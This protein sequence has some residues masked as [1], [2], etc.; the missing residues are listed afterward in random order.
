MADRVGLAKSRA[1]V[2][3][4]LFGRDGEPPLTVGR[5]RIEH[6]LGAGGMGI[7][8][9]AHDEELDR[10]IAV[11]LIA[12]GT[13]DDNERTTSRLRRE[14]KAMARVSHPNVATVFEVGRHDGEVFV[15]MELAPGD[16]LRGWLAQSRTTD[17]ILGVLAQAAR[18]L[19]AAHDAGIVHRDFKP[20][21]V[22][23]GD[24]G[25]V[26][27]L[28]F[29]V[30]ASVGA[31]DDATTEDGLV[32]ALDRVT[33]TGHLVGTPIYMA[34]EQLR[35]EPPDPRSDQFSFFVVAY[36]ALLG[37]RPYEATTL[38]ELR[39]AVEQPVRFPTENRALPRHIESAIR[40]GTS[41]EPAERFA[42][43]HAVADVLASDPAKARRRRVL[44][45]LTI[46]AVGAGA[47]AVARGTEETRC[48]EGRD[49]VS[50][51]WSASERERLAE[52]FSATG[53]GFAESTWTNLDPVLTAWSER[54]AQAHGQACEAARVFET[55]PEAVWQLQR[56][57]L[58]EAWR[59]FD[60]LVEA[61]GT[62][63]GTAVR[64]A[65]N[66]AGQLP[67]AQRCLEIRSVEDGQAPRTDQER[68]AVAAL[69]PKLAEVETLYALG[70]WREAFDTATPLATQAEA[71]EHP[72]TRARALTVHARAAA[73]L[74]SDRRT[75]ETL[76]RARVEAL[77]ANDHGR[78]VRLSIDLA[79]ILD[80]GPDQRERA[81]EIL[82][83]AEG[84]LR[85]LGQPERLR[86]SW[87]LAR[88]AT[89]NGLS[90]YDEAAKTL[91]RALERA[92]AWPEASQSLLVR[93]R[94]RKAYRN[95]A[96]RDT[97]DA[98]AALQTAVESC[99]ATLGETH[100]DCAV[101]RKLTAEMLFDEMKYAEAAEQAQLAVTRLE[102]A[103]GPD[104]LPLVNA[105]Q[106]LGGAQVRQAEYDAADK[107]LQRALELGVALRGDNSFEESITHNRIAHLRGAQGRMAESLAAFRRELEILEATSGGPSI[108]IAHARFNLA[109]T[110]SATDPDAAAP[111]IERAIETYREVGAEDHR[112]AIGA[113]SMAGLIARR[114]GDR[115]GA[116]RHAQ[117]GVA[118]AEA[119]F[120]GPHPDV[121]VAYI[122]LSRAQRDLDDA[123]G[124]QASLERA[125]EIMDGSEGTNPLASANARF[126][127][128]DIYWKDAKRRDA[129]LE[130]AKQA[131]TE[132]GAHDPDLLAEI[133]AWLAERR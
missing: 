99:E 23:V 133:D 4:R 36:E 86:I 43:L 10:Q 15:A 94:S 117:A 51:R 32:V 76:E 114:R 48:L 26:K 41:P 119:H 74:R 17:E 1:T 46:V 50:K 49:R 96:R 24:D 118:Q 126:D 38:E 93:I 40:Q 27:V 42:S 91:Q 2:A 90:R 66:A 68:D 57:C 101:L 107:T 70:R 75:I 5:Y 131:Q 132:I 13:D 61:L 20:E 115:A 60:L 44:T 106:T 87:L 85:F 111:M 88:E 73:A 39:R 30:A 123:A 58:D 105:L 97:P 37:R 82:A 84:A 69:E 110:L 19:A 47:F 129:A 45:G 122:Y 116:L 28:D 127:L 18:G 98:T 65:P 120:D 108:G 130:L 80:D 102:A 8:Y 112:A 56:A 71:I 104:A 33:R 113:R 14:A 100:P 21:N 95:S 67:S 81:L 16:T 83:L 128:A 34:P 54:W 121:A 79:G 12:G 6:R 55:Q 9:A 31:L 7:V 77:A 59:R 72:P 22:M 62:P 103:L 53:L 109:R 89:L 63:D 11:K 78:F 92:E 35:G 52:A 3:R 25:V 125:V 124:M 29:G 64:Q